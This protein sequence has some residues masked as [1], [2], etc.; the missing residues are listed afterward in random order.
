MN[1]I[2]K[3]ILTNYLAQ[4]IADISDLAG[5]KAFLND[6]LTPAELE[7]LAKRLGIAYWLTKGRSYQNIQTNLKVSAKTIAQT[8]SSLKSPGVAGAIKNLEADEWAN[9]W[10]EKINNLKGKQV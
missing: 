4:T 10:V 5:A 1:N 2:L 6:F 8:S 7:T 3:N 9:Q